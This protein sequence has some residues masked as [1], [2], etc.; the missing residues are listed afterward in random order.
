MSLIVIVGAGPGMGLEIARVF[1]RNGF[2]V[3]L[4][5][6]DRAKLDSLTDVLNGEGIAA[7]AFTADL[8]DAASITA[9]FAQIRETLGTV[10]VLEFSAA[11]TSL[12][13]AGVLEVTPANL[14]PQLDFYF[15][16]IHVVKQV[17]DDMIAARTGTIII[18]AG[19]GSVEPSPAMAN[20]NIASAGLRNWI[21]NLHNVL[22]EHGVY[23]AHL[24]I[25]VWIGSG[26]PGTSAAEIAPTYFDLYQARSDA[27]P[28]Y[29]ALT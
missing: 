10:D 1:G 7:T 18:T 4:V 26:Q 19:G 15:S 3:A 17:V 6:R 14:Q 16:A 21:L 11:D 2:T 22:S 12:P 20:I 13:V 23:A 5:A 25:S 29:P 8:L 9:A 28:R 27:D 24:A